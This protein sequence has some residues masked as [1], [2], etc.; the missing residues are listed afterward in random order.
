VVAVDPNNASAQS[1]GARIA[2]LRSLRD[3]FLAGLLAGTRLD[4]AQFAARSR[5]RRETGQRP[6]SAFDDLVSAGEQR[7]PRAL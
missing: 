3:D 7:R 4:Q 1:P 5:S 6:L 2:V